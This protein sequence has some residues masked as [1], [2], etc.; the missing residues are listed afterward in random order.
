[1]PAVCGYS[2]T[3]ISHAPR[4]GALYQHGRCWPGRGCNVVGQCTVW[5][6]LA[7]YLAQSIF[8]PS[9][10]AFGL[11]GR[12]LGVWYAAFGDDAP[13]YQGS[14]FCTG[15]VPGRTTH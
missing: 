3:D 14:A 13:V 2:P 7:V 6:M 8:S 10:R 12:Q 15:T 11:D 1:F 9:R 4:L 5:C